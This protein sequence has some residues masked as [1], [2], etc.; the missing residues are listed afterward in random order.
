[1]GVPT[2]TAADVGIAT[3]HVLALL[4]F[5]QPT[6]QKVSR[7]QLGVD[8]RMPCLYLRQYNTSFAPS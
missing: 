3:D 5:Q 6:F 8:L 7:N 1:M 2:D 4:S